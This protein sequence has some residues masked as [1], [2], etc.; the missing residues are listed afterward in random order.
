MEYSRGINGKGLPGVGG[1]HKERR[2]KAAAKG[3][4]VAGGVRQPPRKERETCGS[5]V[6]L[7]RWRA[8]ALDT[9]GKK[10]RQQRSRVPEVA[11]SPKERGH[12]AAANGWRVAGG[13]R[14]HYNTMDKS[15]GINEEGL[16][17]MAGSPKDDR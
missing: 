14:Q 10:P 8:A 3:A 1:S 7:C 15:R 17:G 5:W 11:G 2:E 13:G 12:E 9:D 16:P 4:S 6:G